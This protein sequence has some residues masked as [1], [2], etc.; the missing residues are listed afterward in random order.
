MN[1]LKVFLIR[2]HNSIDFCE[3]IVMA[4]DYKEAEMI[5]IEDYK[6][7]DVMIEI[8]EYEEIAEK[9]TLLT[10]IIENPNLI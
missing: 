2:Y 6:A 8:K 7:F 10:K 9:A 3:S 4:E 1:G 5:L